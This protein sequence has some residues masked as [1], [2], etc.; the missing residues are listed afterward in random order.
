MIPSPARPAAARAL[1][2]N[3]VSL[4]GTSAVTSGLGFAFWWVA[5]RQLSPEAL[6]AG[7]AAVSAMTLV[8]T[9]GMLGLGTLLI[10]ELPRAGDRA[11]GLMA[12]SLGATALA[13]AA[14]A[15]VAGAAL[16]WVMPGFAW[17][18]AG[19]GAFLLFVLG[20]VLTGVTLVFDQAII[21][22]LRGDLQLWRNLLSAVIKIAALLVLTRGRPDA[23]SVYA[24]WLVGNLLSLGG[25]RGGRGAWPS[26]CSRRLR[27][28][29]C[30]ACCLRRCGTTP[31]TSPCRP[32]A[33]CCPCSWQAR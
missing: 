9:A 23:P 4:V 14:L 33:C 8:G 12:A 2:G 20:V 17:I 28:A 18:T 15:G 1:I 10:S 7:T 30:V 32:P 26:R 11:P 16:P 25:W 27:R 6:G 3:A 5:A 21:G 29:P 24:A 22:R 19:P 31:S 13:C